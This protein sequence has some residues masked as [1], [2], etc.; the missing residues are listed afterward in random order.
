MQNIL[1]KRVWRD[2]KENFLRYLAL[3]L[4]IILGMYLVVSLIGAADTIITG[5]KQLAEQNKCEDGQ[6]GT[7]VPLSKQ[8][9]EKLTKQGITLE[10]MF[11]LDFSIEN[12]STLRVYR[13]REEINLVEIDEGRLAE[14]ENEVVLEKRYV[15]EHSYK[16]GDSI[17]IADEEYQIV[18]IGTT[19]DYEAP[20]KEFSDSAVDS[21]QFGVAFLTEDA[22][23]TLKSG[24]KS[25]KTENYYYAYRLHGKMTD[26]ELKEQIKEFEFSVEEIEDT[27]FQEYWDRTGG[28]KEELEDGIAKLNDGGKELHDGLSEL[29]GHNQELTDAAEQLMAIYPKETPAGQAANDFME[30]LKEYAGGVEEATDGSKELSEGINELDEQTEELMDKYFE[31]DLSNLTMFLEAEDNLRIGAAGEDQVI[32]KLGGLIAGVIVMVLFTYVISV[33]V[34]HGIEK[35]SSVIGALYALGVKRKDL[36]RHYLQLPVTVTI[37]AGLIG[38]GIAFSNIGIP[39]QMQDCYDYFSIPKLKVVYP[40]YLMVYSVIMPPVV[41]LLVNYFVIR[42]SLS[43]TV[44]SLLKEEKKES[45]ISNINLGKMGFIRLFQIRQMLRE[46]R[47]GFTVIFGMFISLLILMLGLDCYVMCNHIKSAAETDTKFEYMYTYK[48]PEEEVVKDGEE[49]FAKTLKR[50]AYGY[51]LEVTLLGIKKENPYFDVNIEKAE[52]KVVISSSVSEKYKLGKGDD[53]V[54]KD[55]EEGR[56]YAFTVTDVVEY[57]TGFYVFMDM[58]SMRKLFEE[59]DDYYNVVFSDKKLDIPAGRLYSTTS[60][61]EL[62]QS[63]GVF[64]D[65]MMPMVSMMTGVAALIFC[66]VMYL[67]LKVMVDRSAFGI[68]LVKIFGYRT[69]EIRKLYLNGNFY[70]ILVGAAISVPLSKKVM[71][72][73]Y[74]YMVSNVACGMNLEFG[75]KLYALIFAAVIVIYLVVNQVLVYRINKIVPAEVLKN[76]E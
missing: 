17:T 1:R 54:L 26:E 16:L 33:F 10:E 15:E 4:L 21:S 51:N 12:D 75:W 45:K 35:E 70:T 40:G 53:I 7:F 22:Y 60:R 66:V 8:E 49:A 71:D 28:K 38:T 5:T 36:I 43:K 64:V 42:K 56:N 58:D 44:L 50:E 27:Y 68:S 72:L 67:M 41:A 62:V 11:Y 52:N 59:S 31:A 18:G 3:G 76:R 73:M 9:K 20:Y 57:S 63:S 39:V 55:E 69:R 74:P 24:G 34:I 6:F 32:N 2:L 30:A 48:Y 25:Q 23:E 37:L 14:K 61:E 29:T 19:P 47:T 65:M 13:N 46:V